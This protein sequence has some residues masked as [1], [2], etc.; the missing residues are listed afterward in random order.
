MLPIFI[1]SYRRSETI[2][3]HKFLEAS[4]VKDYFVVVN[5]GEEAERY[6]KNIAADKIIISNAPR[7]IG[8]NRRW[9][10][11]ELAPTVHWY[12]MM[13]DRV[14]GATSLDYSTGNEKDITAAEVMGIWD[15]SFARADAIGAY[16]IGFATTDNKLFRR[17][18]WQYHSLAMG[19]CGIAL[20]GRTALFDPSLVSREDYQI[21]AENLLQHG[22]VLRNNQVRFKVKHFEPGGIGP[23]GTRLE[24]MLRENKELMRRYPGLFRYNKKKSMP[25]K[26]ELI[27]RLTQQKQ[28]EEWRKRMRG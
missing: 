6:R 19:K 12:L 3:T 18:H 16:L 8:A 21:T 28:I 1:P 9:I 20:K 10:Q 26:S 24:H 2:C 14:Q 23:L 22:L 11:D 7:T 27:I 17:K 15:E 5:D 13:D 25:D 4:G